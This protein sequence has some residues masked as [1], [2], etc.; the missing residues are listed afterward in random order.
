MTQIS[1]LNRRISLC[2]AK[3]VIGVGG[4]PSIIRED[5]VTVWAKIEPKSTSMFSRD[6]FN[7]MEDRDRQTHLITI[8]ARGD[9]AIASSAWAYQQLAG[10]E[11]RW[12][13]ILGVKDSPGKGEFLIIS[14][15]LV[16]R[17]EDVIPPADDARPQP[18]A[19]VNHG[20]EI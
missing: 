17:G 6:G 18:I 7:I 16:Q 15:R 1:D 3:D 10:G 4:T 2:S 8:R 20:V 14:A 11:S 5:V 12:Y 9:V 19:V 13:K